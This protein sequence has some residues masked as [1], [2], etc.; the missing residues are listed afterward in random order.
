[1]MKR[2]GVIVIGQQQYI[3]DVLMKNKW[4]V[5]LTDSIRGYIMHPFKY[6]FPK[7]IFWKIALKAKAV[8]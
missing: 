3:L 1:M 6:L 8:Q 2:S 5:L 7:S 4:F